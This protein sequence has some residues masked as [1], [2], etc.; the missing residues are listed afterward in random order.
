MLA[1]AILSCWFKQEKID[2]RSIKKCN[3][4]NFSAYY[5]AVIEVTSYKR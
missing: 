5:E 2:L 3:I 4:E 1:T